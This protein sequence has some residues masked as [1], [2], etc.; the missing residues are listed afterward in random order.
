MCVHNYIL[1][2]ESIAYSKILLRCHLSSTCAYMSLSLSL[3]IYLYI[4]IYTHI[5]R[6]RY[7][8]IYIHTY[9]C[10]NSFKKEHR[11]FS[12]QGTAIVVC[13]AQVPGS[14]RLSAGFGGL[15]SADRKGLGHQGF[16][17]WGLRFRDYIGFRVWGLRFIGIRV[18]GLGIKV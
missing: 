1:L 15:G 5:Y 16:R 12:P 6:Y 18:Q 13:Q 8:Y 2:Y 10:S 11:S 3:S 4:Y 14:F 7:I 17:V 9:I